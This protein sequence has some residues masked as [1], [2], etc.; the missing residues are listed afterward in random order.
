MVAT[1]L[2]TS[3]ANSTTTTSNQPA[4][5][6]PGFFGKLIMENTA[7]VS[8][9]EWAKDVDWSYERR[10]EARLDA[11]YDARCDRKDDDA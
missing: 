10:E 8:L 2:L 4:R 6:N 3:L 5:S 9:P 1:T 11:M 7:P